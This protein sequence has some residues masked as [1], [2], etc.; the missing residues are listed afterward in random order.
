MQELV[1]DSDLIVGFNLKYDLHIL[2]KCGILEYQ[3]LKKVWDCQAVQFIIQNQQV[4]FPSLNGAA[5]YW[6]LAPKFDL[7]E[8][9]YWS[10][11]IDTP[12]IPWKIL[13]EYAR[14]DAVLTYHVYLAQKK[15]LDQHDKLRQLAALL[16]QDLVVLAEM[17][18]NGLKY[19]TEESLKR[20]EKTKQE[21]RDID[22]S[23]KA[24]VG[25]YDF[26]FSS[27][28]QLSAILYGGTI[29]F[30]RHIPYE[31]T[32]KSGPRIGLTE[33]RYK[34]EKTPV[35]FPP[36]V[37]PTKGS[38]LKKL[39][40][41]SVEEGVLSQ[42]RCSGPAKQVVGL[43]IKRKELERLNSTYYEGFPKKMMEMDWPKD[44]LHG[45]LNQS[46]VVTGRLSSS[47]PNIQN[48]PPE[49]DE[50]VKTRFS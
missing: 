1:A 30:V 3:D 44:E 19:D 48:M 29:E 6:N 46:V 2:R 17:E 23:I 24:I 39:G 21:I 9:E 7:V 15:Y 16:N 32:Y 37:K 14:G 38:E 22:A 47:S 28:D 35:T 4:R 11:G 13:H 26:N 5:E 36:L 49:V 27:N 8:K 31:H 12:D 43:I 41:F 25:N 33:T 20:S 34:H 18:W 40:Y 42:L 10:K 50:L 45:Q